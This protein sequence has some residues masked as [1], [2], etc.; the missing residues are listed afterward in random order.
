MGG[1]RVMQYAPLLTE[2]PSVLKTKFVDDYTS[3]FS[4]HKDTAYTYIKTGERFDYLTDLWYERLSAG[5]IDSAYAVYNDDYY[6][7][8]LWN[9]FVTYSR[10][11]L[12][13]FYKKSMDD[14]SI[15]DVTSDAKVIVDIGCGIGYTTSTLAQM[16]PNA[17]VYGL[18][19]KDTKQW[20]FCENMS[21]K[22]NFTMIDSIDLVDGPADFIFASEFFEHIL[23]P[24]EYV[25][26][27]VN[28][29]SP[30]Y[31]FISNAFNTRSIG[32]FNT[33]TLSDGTNVESD[34]ISKLF[35]KSVKDLRYEKIKTTLFNNK[36]NVWKKLV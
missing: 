30:K 7:T 34:R 23:D 2:K 27:V 4:I 32:H 21:K 31:M 12:R 6:F 33:Y 14:K 24:I 5:D 25:T 17:K 35:N 10:T 36:P 13:R 29:L 19:L 11:Y 16:Y 3:L 15:L 1:G 26:N 18:N 9:C 22:Y 28:K 20:S 8:D